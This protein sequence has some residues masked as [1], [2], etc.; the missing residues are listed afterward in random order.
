HEVY[1]TPVNTVEELEQRVRRAQ[2]MF[3]MNELHITLIKCN[4][5]RCAYFWAIIHVLNT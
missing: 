1:S 4:A 3:T 2:T 5:K